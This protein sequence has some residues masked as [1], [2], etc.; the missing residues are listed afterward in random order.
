[1]T[2]G[3]CI[4]SVHG[5]VEKLEVDPV[6]RVLEAS[7]IE[8]QYFLGLLVVASDR[9]EVS[10]TSL[11]KSLSTEIADRLESFDLRCCYD[12]SLEQVEIM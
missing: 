4:F 9:A 12:C 3:F 5:F 6:W 8:K 11:S 2:V 7:C 1:M 10:F